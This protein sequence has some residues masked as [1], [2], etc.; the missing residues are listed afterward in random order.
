MIKVPHLAP[1][2]EAAL[3]QFQKQWATYQKLV[4]TNSLASKQAGQFL[5]AALAGVTKP[6]A[7]V[8]IACG[9]AG[10]MKQVLAGT[11]IK[12]YHGIDLSEPA[13]ALAAKNLNDVPFEVE[14]D[15]IDFVEANP[16]TLSGAACPFII[17]VRRGSFACSRRFIARPVTFS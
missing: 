12:H 5:H 6:F 4:D 14:L 16:L 8:D 10:L 1:G 9:D 15:Q 11:K 7:F 17:L 13:L 3:K 2:D